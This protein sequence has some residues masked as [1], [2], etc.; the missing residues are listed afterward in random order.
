MFG[1]QPDLKQ[2]IKLLAFSSLAIS[3]PK[4]MSTLSE[5]FSE[6]PGWAK[7]WLETVGLIRGDVMVKLTEKDDGE[8]VKFLSSGE[9][10]LLLGNN[11]G[12]NKN[13][14]EYEES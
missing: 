8:G 5:K 1:L 2:A 3:F 9:I 4:A 13:D 7:L 14:E 11:K 6:G 10:K 12:G